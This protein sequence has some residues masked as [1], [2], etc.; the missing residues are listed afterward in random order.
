[1]SSSSR[2]I[3]LDVESHHP[4]CL[5][6]F[7][8]HTALYPCPAI[9]VQCVVMKRDTFGFLTFFMIVDADQF[10]FDRPKSDAEKHPQKLHC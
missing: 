10:R 6:I 5:V 3:I 4:E 8:G 7:I 1:M 9:L 2:E